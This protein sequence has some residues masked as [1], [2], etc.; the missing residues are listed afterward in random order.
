MSTVLNGIFSGVGVIVVF[1]LTAAWIAAHPESRR[2]RRAA[3]ALAMGYVVASVYAV[4]QALGW[5]LLTHQFHA[6]VPQDAAQGRT[7]IVL[8]GGGG[9]TVHGFGGTMLGVPTGDG[10]ER[11]LEAAR[12]FTMTHADWII[13]SG[14]RLDDRDEP[15]GIV[16]RDQLVRIGIP[17]DRIVVETQSKT[18]HEQA[19]LVGPMLKSLGAEHVVLVTSDVHMP[20]SLGAF[21]VSGIQAVPAI[22]PS[23]AADDPLPR[24]ILPSNEGLSRSRQVVHEIVGIMYYAVRGWWT[25]GTS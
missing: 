9:E 1:V 16:M 2:A 11:V 8:L 3:L 21:R 23:T 25:P 22:A 14:G 13:S 20:R 6:L 10:L 5:A 24:R 18:T 4:P 17:S 7:A 15:D 12:V 19:V